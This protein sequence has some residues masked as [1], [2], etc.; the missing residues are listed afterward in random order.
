MIGDSLWK[1]SFVVCETLKE[2]INATNQCKVGVL[3]PSRLIFDLDPFK[4]TWEITSDAMSLYFSW[5]VDAKHTIILTDVDGIYKDGDIGNNE[6]LITEIT[7]TELEVMGHT[8]VD[9]C[10]ASFL[11]NKKMECFVMNAKHSKQIQKYLLGIRND[12]L[13]TL[14]KGTES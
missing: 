3:L 11:Q 8:A 10:T 14:I 13:G 6:K 5:L 9:I 7:A 1:S 4:Y 12:L 2:V